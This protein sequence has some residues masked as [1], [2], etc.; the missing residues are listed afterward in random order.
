MSNAQ[1]ERA[2]SYL[3][4]AKIIGAQD[5]NVLVSKGRFSQRLFY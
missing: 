4:A 3:L 5:P 1:V 2:L